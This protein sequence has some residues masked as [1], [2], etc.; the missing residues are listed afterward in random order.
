VRSLLRWLILAPLLSCTSTPS[1]G[2]AATPRVRV[3]AASADLEGDD[4]MVIAGGIHPGKSIGQEGRLRAIAVVV[5]KPGAGRCAIVACDVLMV[6]RDLLDEAA[7]RIEKAIGI[8][9]ANILINCTHTHHAP[10]TCD[11]HAYGRDMK[12]CRRLVDGI[13]KAVQDANANLADAELSYRLGHESSV[14]QNS[15]LLLKDNTIFWIGDKTDAV[16]PTGPFDPE[17]PVLAFRSPDQKL[18][19][20][21]FNHSTHTIGTGKPGV[22]SP[23]F[24]GMA[25]QEL[26]AELGGTFEF[27]EG[28]SGSTHN[29]GVP[30]PEMVLRIKAAVKEALEKTEPHAVDLIAAIKREFAYRVRKIDDAKEDEAVSAYCKRRAAGGADGIIEAFRM[31]RKELAPHQGEER[32]TWLQ[33]LRIGDVAIAAVPAEYFTKLGL[34]IK[35]RSP[36]RHTIVAELANDWIGYLPDRPAFELGGYQT[37]TGFHSY[38]EPGTGEAIADEIVR[39]LRELAVQ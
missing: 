24:Y 27:L 37:W 33:V 13:D 2:V 19:A 21:I 5:E 34:D 8:P 28:A 29:L 1:T 11:V 16:R 7:T 14:G 22:R 30:F 23:S 32:K 4:S 10:S 20:A 12:F 15:R 31:A 38:T 35:R 9:F 17:L 3:G 6:N 25:T 18:R 26:E 39:M 36:F